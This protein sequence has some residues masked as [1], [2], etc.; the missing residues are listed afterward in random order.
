MPQG[1]LT[2]LTDHFVC[3]IERSG[4]WELCEG[5]QILLILQGNETGWGGLKEIECHPNHAGIEDQRQDRALEQAPDDLG[6]EIR[7]PMEKAVERPEEPAQQEVQC[8]REPIIR[9]M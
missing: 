3:P 1:N 8:S 6:I 5:H 9:S 4:V 7:R 2:H